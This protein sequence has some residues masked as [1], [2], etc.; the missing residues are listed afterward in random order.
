M[1][2]AFILAAEGSQPPALAPVRMHGAVFLPDLQEL[3]AQKR[4]GERVVRAQMHSAAFLAF[5]RR[6]HDDLAVV[7][8]VERLYGAY[9]LMR[10]ADAYGGYPDGR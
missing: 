1:E 3:V 6:V 4:I 7:H 10:V 5:P 9:E 2:K 8:E